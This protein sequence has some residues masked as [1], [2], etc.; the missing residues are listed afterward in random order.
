M[1]RR[2]KEKK[3]KKSSG[4]KWPL[5]LTFILVIAAVGAISGITVLGVYLAGG[6]EERIINPEAIAF[7]YDESL[8]N[9]STGQLEV[10]D[11]F[12]LTITTPT[13]PVTETAVTLSF[14]SGLFHKFDG[15][16]GV[17][18]IDNEIIQVP[19]VVT[20]GQ[21]FQVK[22]IRDN[23]LVD[24]EGKEIL[25]EY[26]R[27][28]DWIVGGISVLQ[29][30]SEY[31]MIS[32]VTLQIAVDVP[33]YMTETV[34]INSTTETTN[35]IVTGE[36]FHLDT[37]FYPAKSE[38]IYSDDA[39][40][41]IDEENKRVKHAYY[42]AINVDASSLSTRYDGRY[43][44][45]FIAGDQAVDNITMMG[46]TFRDA[47]TQIATENLYIDST[48][49][50]F[51]SQVL[52]YL[53]S[54]T[55]DVS[56][57]LNIRIGAASVYNFT[58]SKAGSTVSMNADSTMRIY[59]NQYLYDQS[60]EFL[61]VNIYSTSG[62]IIENMLPNLALSFEYNGSDPTLDENAFLTVRGGESVVVD[63]VTYYKPYS[64]VSNYNY[65]YWD[66]LSSQNANITVSVVLLIENEDGSYS[67]FGEP[68][69]IYN[70]TLSVERHAE[71]AIS[72]ADSS[73]ID[74]M[75]NYNTDGSI[76]PYTLNL[77]GLVSIPTDNIYQSYVFFA[78]FGEGEK[79][80]LVPTANTIIGSTG[81]N[82][83]LTGYYSTDID[84]LMLFAI[85]G[86][87]IT[88]Q[89][90]GTFRLYYATI[91]T[92]NGV[93]V[94]EED[95]S[96]NRTYQIAMMCNEYITVTCEKSL[97]QDSIRA[98][99]IDVSAFPEVNGEIAIN[100]GATQT[101]SVTF[102][103]MAESVSVFQEEYDNGYINLFVRSSQGADVSS[104][105]SIVSREF[106]IDGTSGE[107]V[108]K[109]QVNVNTGI[110]IDILNGIYI[111][112]FVLNYNDNDDTN[113]D[114]VIDAPAETNI[115]IYS[116][117]ATNLEIAPEGAYDYNSFIT[118]EET[119]YVNQSLNAGGNFS[120]TISLGNVELSSVTELLARLLGA[121]NSY[122]TITDQKDRIDT[123]AGNWKFVVSNGS[124]DAVNLNGQTFTF[125]QASGAEVTLALA[126]TDGNATSLT[127]GQS[128]TLNI[129]SV[130]VT[131]ADSTDSLDPFTNDDYTEET[132]ISNIAV[133]KYG[134]KSNSATDTI[135]LSTLVRFYI[136]EEAGRTQYNNIRFQLSQ[137]YLND[138]TLTDDMIVDL[139]GP[140]GML[141]LFNETGVIS[142]LDGTA[143]SIRAAL[144]GQ[145]IT[146]V[147]I[148]KDFAV[149]HIIRF[150]I[151]DTG[152]NG[153][154][155]STLS[156]TLL[157]N[158]SISS[159]NYPN[160]GETLYASA[161]L[162]LE[163][164]VTNNYLNYKSGIYDNSFASLYD[165]GVSMYY[166]V[167][168][169]NNYILQDTMPSSYVGIFYAQE[170]NVGGTFIPAGTIIFSDFWNVPS[171]TYSITFTPDGEN[172]FTL[173][174]TLSF[175]VTRDLAIT[176]LENVY[177]IMN[178]GANYGISNFVSLHRM[179]T[180]G[181]TADTAING[182]DVEYVF[183]DYLVYE[184][185]NV[186]KSDDAFFVF[187][188]NTT[189]LI[190][191]LTIN[192][193]VRGANDIIL[194]RVELGSVEIK[195]KLYSNG[196]D[197]D[198]Y[199]YIAS[200]ISY[201]SN[202]SIKAEVQNV[203][204]T[205]YIMLQEGTWFLNDDFAILGTNSFNIYGNLRTYATDGNSQ[206][207][208]NYLGVTY[209]STGHTVIDEEGLEITL[210]GTR[211]TTRNSSGR[212]LQGLDSE[213]LFLVVYF[214][215]ANENYGEK[216]EFPGSIAVMY[217]PIVI[218]SIG[219]D[220]VNYESEL[221]A[222]SNLATAMTDPNTLIENGIYDIV[223][224]GQV[225][226]ILSEY[227][228]GET[229]ANGLYM[230]TNSSLSVNIEYYPI[231]TTGSVQ[232]NSEIVKLISIE[233][234]QV[235]SGEYERVGNL[236]LNHL[237]NS[238]DDFYL[239]LRYTI[240]NSSDSRE[241]FY[242]LKVIPDVIV[243]ESVYGYN[244]NSEFLESEVNSENMVEL[245]HIFGAT[246]LNENQKRFNITKVL[247]LVEGYAI[248]EAY[249]YLTITNDSEQVISTLDAIIQ[250]DMT[251]SVSRVD[252]NDD[253]TGDLQLITITTL[254]QIVDLADY[255]ED[256]ASGDRFVIEI[257]AGEGDLF[258]NGQQI[259]VSHDT[260][261]DLQ[262]EVTEEMQVWFTLYNSDNQL[263][264][265][266]QFVTITKDEQT[267]DLIEVFAEA[268]DAIEDFEIATGDILTIKIISGEGDI[269]YNGTEI[270]SDLKEEN[271]VE[272]VMAGE[273]LYYTEETWSDYVRIYFSEDYSKM[274]YTPYTS[275]QLTINIRHSYKG[276][277]QDDELAVIGGEQYYT[278][279]LNTT[280]YNY[281][282]RFAED[283]KSP[284]ITDENSTTYTWEVSRE[285]I[286]D[287]RTLSMDI[288]LLEGYI[289]GSAQSY[290]EVWNIL[291][292]SMT[293]ERAANQEIGMGTES[294]V[295]SFDYDNS[296]ANQGQFNIT[297]ADYISSDR[298]IEF[299]LYT[300][301]GY[302]ATLIINISAT[303]SYEIIAGNSTLLGGN[304][305]QFN[306]VFAISLN[307]SETP[308]SGSDYIVTLD[309]ITSS[310]KDI[311]GF[312]G[313]DFIIFDENATF[314]VA[315]LIRDYNVTLSF[316]VTF[317]E[318]AGSS[319]VNQ[320]FTFTATLTLGRNV[321]YKTS[322]NGGAVLAGEDL[323]IYES[324]IFNT[325]HSYE[326]TEIVYNGSSS[327]PAFASIEGTT[328]HTNYIASDTNVDVNMIVTLYFN[329]SN[330]HTLTNVAYQTF[331]ITY[332]F[333]AY[334][335]VTLDAKYPSPNGEALTREYLDDGTSFTNILTGFILHKP[336]FNQTEGGEPLNRITIKKG[337]R[338]GTQ[339]EYED[340]ISSITDT[341][342]LSISIIAMSNA[343]VYTDTVK[344]NDGADENDTNYV[345]S[346]E[347]EYNKNITFKRGTWTSTKTENGTKISF[348]DN[349]N[350]SYVT[351]RI[352][353]QEVSCD[354]TVYILANSIIAQINY[355]SANVASG[356][357]SDG[358]SSILVSYETLYV[359][360]TST[361]ALFGQN[362]MAS[363]VFSNDLAVT[364]SYY[365]VFAAESNY[366]TDSSTNFYASYPQYISS[367]NAGQIANIDLG[368]SMAKDGNDFV[369]V[370]TYEVAAFES[371]MLTVAENGLIAKAGSTQNNAATWAD[372]NKLTNSDAN[373]RIFTSLTLTHRIELVYGG[374][375]GVPIAYSYYGNMLANFEFIKGSTINYKLDTIN[376]ISVFG[377]S[378]LNKEDGS[379]KAEVI[380]SLN[381][382]FKPSID[383][384]VDEKISSQNNYIELEVNYEIP[385]MVELFG[386]RHP[387][388]GEYIN[389]ADFGA[390]K[391]NL[392][393]E[394]VNY[395]VNNKLNTVDE[396]YQD[397]LD[398]YISTYNFADEGFR[399]Q[400]QDDGTNKYVY[401]FSSAILNAGQYAYDYMLL[402][403]GADNQG[404]FVLTRLAYT[405]PLDGTTLSYEKEF[406]IVV[407]VVPDYQITY[408]GNVV[409]NDLNSDAVTNQGNPYNIVSLTTD[410]NTNITHY[411]EFTLTSSSTVTDGHVS[412]RHTNG[413][414]TS[415]ELATSNFTITMAVP[416]TTI[417]GIEYNNATNINQK[418]QADL[419]RAW[420]KSNNTYTLKE[421]FNTTF[422]SAKEVIFG[423]QYYYIQA[424]DPYGFTYILYFSLQSS[425][426]EPDIKADTISLTELGYI[427]FGAQYELISVQE[428]VKDDET[429]FYIN[430]QTYPPETTDASVQLVEIT[431]IEAYL[432][433]ADPTG[434]GGISQKEKGG[435]YEITN[436]EDQNKWPNYNEDISYFEVPMLNYVT[437]DSI[438]FYDMDDNAIIKNAIE[439]TKIGTESGY[440]LATTTSSSGEESGMA[441]YN[442]LGT[443]NTGR[444]PYE[445]PGEDKN[446]LVDGQQYLP[447]QVPRIT[448]TS[449]FEDSNTA[450][451]QM[452]VRLKYKKDTTIE[453]Y[454]LK[455]NV[456]IT[457]EVTIMSNEGAS[458]VR[459]G[460]GFN[461]SGE[462]EVTSGGDKLDSK[463]VTYLNDTLEVLVN[464]GQSTSFEMYLYR[465]DSLYNN[466]PAIVDISNTGNSWA[467]TEYISISQYL[468]TNVQLGDE[469][470]IVPRDQNATFYYVY[471]NGASATYYQY[472][473]FAK[474][475]GSL[476]IKQAGRPNIECNILIREIAQDVIY[477]EN[478]SLLEARN[479]YNVR[480][481]YIVS[482]NFGGS[483]SATP[484]NYR[485]SKNYYV[486]GRYFM[487]QR[488][489]TAQD[490]IPSI[491][492]TE[493]QGQRI[494]LL[495]QWS[496]TAY[497]SLHYATS[498][499]QPD[500][501]NTIGLS[502]A[503]SVLTFTLDATDGASGNAEVS[504]NGTI[505]FYNS[506]TYDQYVKIIIRMKVSG[507]DRE[508]SDDGGLVTLGTLKLR[509]K[510]KF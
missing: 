441:I 185:N 299:T 353:Y 221:E 398:G 124:A 284:V 416:G 96:G 320:V 109:Y 240:S 496:G 488:N 233:S 146:K 177:Y 184:N 41:N 282:V 440:T 129:S 387:T 343:S 241:F 91:I 121:D 225:T 316:I 65:S 67:L 498:E 310:S 456:T 125:R 507:A 151:S 180:A 2:L 236:Y 159:Q 447:F 422:T 210:T 474:A 382:Y 377:S 207:T 21:P 176:D 395:Q 172:Y 53:F 204:S 372:I 500:T 60:A 237:T 61:G 23:Y 273:D 385:S 219:Y 149:D 256:I 179:S 477:V 291:E 245:D 104:Y 215:S 6:F 337:N 191:T 345:V 392:S 272:S 248:E 491:N 116:P 230:I 461:L 292:I 45:S 407:K 73:D 290:T 77:D 359:D 20:L 35:Q 242:V 203:G 483:G 102:R 464:G 70:F 325:N 263:K 394:S 86:S 224:A 376:G 469:I 381:Y 319:Y 251:I 259:Q 24:S 93:P 28:I 34:A 271:A 380:F 506:F 26:N 347:I 431:G 260:I 59:L 31:N 209:D 5:W 318:S 383:I 218:S 302:L 136:G 350:D 411:S 300:E 455:V 289:A 268:F 29:A 37:I 108:L 247:P 351:F 304:S 110:S 62:S 144:S 283:G 481:Y 186:T 99:E 397:I 157:S 330:A 348:N 293:G 250:R 163:N 252:E 370:G 49:E 402:P 364:G 10:T 182:I 15:D 296:Q 231:D 502:S 194:N 220:Y 443:N 274:Y 378:S 406:Y 423:T 462:F 165:D 503:A 150:T 78:Y 76:N 46:Y 14:T 466:T 307:G 153:A 452:V 495:A 267:I 51:Y 238:I 56:S 44:V 115:C 390:G 130:G 468:R 214:G 476:A 193:L 451:A 435:G 187:D 365:I 208:S 192:Y 430:S 276:G 434:I 25:D 322:A 368:Y 223:T 216:P 331:T 87:T 212:L 326:N 298:Q 405:V 261:T 202:Y 482:V 286:S 8:Y 142:G 410:S 446:N 155:S 421:G 132:D 30:R 148:N 301:Q 169:G 3:A 465:D 244:G 200:L 40:S 69:L 356:N 317:A 178:D 277:A 327:S 162:E 90:T 403:L 472:Q 18:Y 426:S 88:L 111:S 119:I 459:D 98:G 295:V 55:N 429:E 362:R 375:N 97:Y 275:E 222:S 82:Y 95:Q 388:T 486:T 509:W 174:R 52:G 17:T 341:N 32:A 123:L 315:D 114:W 206:S 288:R 161:A 226:Q 113:I 171:Q 173:S 404:D 100:Q 357:Y 243:E 170:T 145:T 432:F 342:N 128:I 264:A 239:A 473:V 270:F 42:Q 160:N 487:L 335:S 48:D 137:Q 412:V 418:L 436:T 340:I 287:A 66:L 81:Y 386:V 118:G 280:T 314:I 334:K 438:M 112:Q 122:V 265:D 485:V 195:I 344:V 133:S 246:T 71:S 127:N 369:Y 139:F 175:V 409:E 336:A 54:S 285:D 329:Y 497:F 361:T 83:D 47:A 134:A 39:N 413:D 448:D 16:D 338:K 400:A 12:T 147:M 475:D 366:S 492:C 74:V 188:Y 442:G 367:S 92:E 504:D 11:D 414:N 152:E 19:E 278:F 306:N 181:S 303:A 79:D 508:I 269:I 424:V 201:D 493:Y 281:S 227:T 126:S 63:G 80:A 13:D 360:K 141:T 249:K 199:E 415:V 190:T 449:L 101:I 255:F 445:N 313:T 428:V 68:S 349:G 480:K 183:S 57:S 389:E 232:T 374:S 167:R 354:Y 234:Q 50:L 323:E 228:F 9:E 427:D 408:G 211:L 253:V 305:Y 439:P 311:N 105:F 58:V 363:V 254:E 27:S 471:N 43:D 460:V 510:E 463:K 379:T 36:A 490:I 107:G 393:F 64:N 499:L 154:I 297:F 294:A 33:V 262:V 164:T 470:Q 384:D 324:G 7:S 120:T 479:Y 196:D 189:E 75:L 308:L 131:Y 85:N 352:T 467:R 158:L 458:P 401:L 312:D 279:I 391:A 198:L 205:E 328:I 1:K 489:Y 346:S 309:S 425:Y 371:N 321:T 399:I 266:S 355:T 38:Y 505:T 22:L 453:Y 444:L 454:D 417:E 229:V 135:N 117:V 94:Y 420:G 168:S 4:K 494:S 501:T 103:V 358:D 235:G 257:I 84:N 450:Q 478:A 484:F 258:Y 156:L 332:S 333:N 339:L 138:S 197:F 373:Q 72:W 433:S 419:N 89:N 396:S 106:S 213:K 166:I 457:R 217:V 143:A 437:V 140:D